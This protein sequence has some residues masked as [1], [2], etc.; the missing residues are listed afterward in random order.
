LNFALLVF[1]QYHSTTWRRIQLSSPSA[2]ATR[3]TM[4]LTHVHALPIFGAQDQNPQ[5]LSRVPNRAKKWM[6][7]TT[8]SPDKAGVKMISTCSRTVRL[9]AA[10][11]RQR[12]AGRRVSWMSTLRAPRG[13]HADATMRLCKTA[14]QQATALLHRGREQYEI[15]APWQSEAKRHNT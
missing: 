15:D 8:N 10:S 2:A 12:I 14:E 7:G 3:W 1:P 11:S 6:L 5:S 13:S 4:D 9:S